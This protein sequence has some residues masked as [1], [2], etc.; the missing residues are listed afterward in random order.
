MASPHR[1]LR[2]DSQGDT[3]ESPGFSPGE[4][5]KPTGRLWG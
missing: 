5:V 2:R 4:E 1:S 3:S